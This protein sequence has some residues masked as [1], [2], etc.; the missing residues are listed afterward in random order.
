[1]GRRRKGNGLIGTERPIFLFAVTMWDP[2]VGEMWKGE[3]GNCLV[4]NDLWGRL[5]GRP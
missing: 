5:F 1:V 2:V 3:K 4:V